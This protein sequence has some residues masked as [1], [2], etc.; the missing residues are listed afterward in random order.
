[1]LVGWLSLWCEVSLV[2]RLAHVVSAGTEP[3]K[4][5]DGPSR[6]LNCHHHHQHPRGEILEIVMRSRKHQ[7]SPGKLTKGSRKAVA[8]MIPVRL[9]TRI[10]IPVSRKG[11]EKSI[12][13]SLQIN[14]RGVKIDKNI[15]YIKSIIDGFRLLR[16]HTPQ[17][18]SE[19]RKKANNGQNTRHCTARNIIIGNFKANIFYLVE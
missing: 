16:T 17:K 1:M 5:E 19:Q 15:F 13:F 10:V 12:T 18:S 6:G 2:V 11:T 9:E 3:F 4:Q 8:D 7:T 14:K